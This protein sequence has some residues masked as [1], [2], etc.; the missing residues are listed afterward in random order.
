MSVQSFRAPGSVELF[1][2]CDDFTD[3]WKGAP[4]AILQHGFPRN[5]NLWYA[6]VP[7]L[8]RYLRIV[9]PDLRGIGLSKVP[10]E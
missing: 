9:R 6:W 2:R 1:Y 10:A 8:G 3:P 7:L 4:T 5:S